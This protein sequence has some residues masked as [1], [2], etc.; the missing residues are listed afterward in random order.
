[1]EHKRVTVTIT[2]EMDDYFKELAKAR[3]ISKDRVMAEILANAIKPKHNERGAGRKAKFTTADIVYM[4]KY[5]DSGMT[6]RQI[7]DLY[8]CGAGTVHKLINEELPTDMDG[9][10]TL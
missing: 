1:M 9:Q 6:Y 2:P 7:A 5:K 10:I 3:G 8:H 4:K